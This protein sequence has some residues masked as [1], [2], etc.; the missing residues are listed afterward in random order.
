MES[1][2]RAGESPFD[3]PEGKTGANAKAEEGLLAQIVSPQVYITSLPGPKNAGR[4]RF[5]AVSPSFWAILPSEKSSDNPK[6]GSFES[7]PRLQFS[8]P[9]KM[10]AVEKSHADSKIL[11]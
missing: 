5:G 4:S 11:S 3:R 7:S 8:L 10:G 6:I 1:T 2:S 9:P